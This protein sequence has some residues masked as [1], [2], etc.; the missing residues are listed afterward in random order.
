MRSGSDGR[1]GIPGRRPRQRP[2][3][4]FLSFVLLRQA[5]SRAPLRPGI[6]PLLP[7][8]LHPAAHP[9]GYS[10][11]AYRPAAAQSHV[12][13]HMCFGNECADVPPAFARALVRTETGAYRSAFQ[14]GEAAERR[15]VGAAKPHQ[16]GDVVGGMRP[17]RVST[18]KE[19]VGELHTASPS[20]GPAWHSQW[21]KLFG[22]KSH[23]APTKW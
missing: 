4:L 6:T 15:E 14:A 7:A 22:P 17:M 16:P 1:G 3:F 21:Q 13:A 11:Q 23:P 2:L 9:S 8:D 20:P 18:L 19:R 12:L 5:S 10:R